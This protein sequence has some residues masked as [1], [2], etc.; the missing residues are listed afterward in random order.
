MVANYLWSFTTADPA[1]TVESVL[2]ANNAV[3][4]AL[5]ANL[6]VTFSEPV[7]VMGAWYN[8]TCASSGTHPAAVSGGPNTFTIDPD[9]DFVP[10]EL[11]TVT[12]ENTLITD[13]DSL[14]PYD[15]MA[16]DY[17]WMFT[18]TTCGLTHTLISAVQGNTDVS[19]LA[20]SSVTLEGIVTA[21]LQ[22]TTQLRGVFLQTI[23]GLE[24]ADKVTSEGIFVY[25]GSAYTTV[26]V[27]NHV[28][29]TGTVVEYINTSYGQMARM[30]EI[31]PV[32]SLEVCATG[33]TLPAPAEINLPDVVD[34]GFKLEPFEGMLVTFPETLTVQQ[35]YF[36]ARFGQLTL[37]AG[38]RIPQMNNITRGGGSIY[39][40]TRMLILDD[41]SHTQNLDV[42]SY[43][44][45]YGAL[46]AGDTTAASLVGV[47][48]QGRINS[49]N[50]TADTSFPNIYYRLHPTVAPTFT[51]T[52]PRPVDVPD[53]GGRLK[54]VGTNVLNYFTTIDCGNP[55]T[56]CSYDPTSGYAAYPDTPRGADTTAEFTRQQDKIV[57]ALAL[58]NA[59]VYGLMEIES[60]DGAAA[61]QALVNALNT[62]L[63]AQG[64]SVVYAAVADPALGY[65]QAVDGG[66]YIQ[67]ALIYKTNTV[68]PVGASLSTDNTIF[69]RSP[70]AQEFEE[71]ATGE[72]FVVVTN[73]F[74]S[75]GSC[76]TDGSLNEDQ[77]DGQGCWNLLRVQQAEALLTFIN[78]SLVPLD[79]DVL[80]I[81]DL[82]AY[83]AE[84]PVVTLTTGGLINQIAALV[85]EP[86]RYTY[87][88]DGSAGYLDHALSTA[89]VNTEITDVAIWHINADEPSVIDY[90][91]EYKDPATSP[92]SPDFY[93]ADPYRSSDHDAVIIGLELANT[94]NDAPILV[95]PIPDQQIEP[96]KAYTFTFSADTFTDL[97]LVYGDELA[98]D[99]TQQDGAPLPAWLSFDPLTRTFSGT[100]S[101][102]DTG[103]LHIKV[104]A[105][106]KAFATAHDAFDLKVYLLFY[107]PAIY[108]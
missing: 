44:P 12:L 56:D 26:G 64:S 100:P 31:S 50:S 34:D 77:L 38:G 74:K 108:K 87:V 65:F 68:K 91:T 83:G 49:A 101:M 98:Y 23:P 32:T 72:Q 88:F 22:L 30:T 76:P 95:N 55:D 51:L 29:L 39:D 63:A 107:M 15:E 59:D 33:K 20:G 16:A 86:D 18:T 89:A 45:T 47:L 42:M 94:A 25:T 80:V 6:S 4:V 90:N 37:G 7:D 40:Y 75:K 28:R 52:N 102:S 21:D 103:T 58:E 14:D 9:S 106:D 61:P 82:N 8:V 24:D 60:W 104:V 93:Q 53:V 66:D 105:L 36:Q 57:K 71:N 3:G 11:C 85:P 99:V 19:P 5:D 1:P 13:R 97:D 73:H 96:G 43:Y 67:V 27:G 69:S 84:D 78:T 2:P 54:V 46:R 70:F 17:I 92:S 10:G 81:G 62:Y 41:G 35:N 79:E 48:D